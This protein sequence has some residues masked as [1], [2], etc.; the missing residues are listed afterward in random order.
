MELRGRGLPIIRQ[1]MRAFN[2]TEPQLFN[3]SGGR[4]VRLRLSR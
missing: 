1:E 4:F 2:E 3:D